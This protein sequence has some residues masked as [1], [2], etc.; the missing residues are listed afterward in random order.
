MPSKIRINHAAARAVARKSQAE[1]LVSFLRQVEN[2]AKVLTP[3]DTGRLRGSHTIRVFYRGSKAVGQIAAVTDYALA[4]HEGWSRTAPIVPKR[5]KALRFKV[6]NRT[7]IVAKVNAPASYAGRPWLWRALQEV[8]ARHG[9]QATRRH[10]G[11][12]G[13]TT[14][15]QAHT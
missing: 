3:V 12:V 2:R 9:V 5:K 14:W 8:S 1:N 15:T 11:L 7:V 4:V 6:G 13:E 10:G